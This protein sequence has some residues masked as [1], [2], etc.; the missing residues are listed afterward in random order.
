MRGIIAL[1]VL[2]LSPGL[3]LAADSVT[4]ASEVFVEKA[5]VAPDGRTRI[6]LD[7]PKLVMPGDNLVFVL[8]YRNEG[9]APA[10][11]FSVTNPMP[12]A[13]AF[14]EAPGNLAQYSVDNGRNWG[15]LATLRVQ[16]QDGRWRSARPEDVTHVRWT[17]RQPLPVGASGKLTFRGAVR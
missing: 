8:K 6:M 14:R 17:F 16:E 3:A 4:L 7:Q 10:A 1:L 12:S 5:V 15:S 2:L 9:N 11:H 13:V